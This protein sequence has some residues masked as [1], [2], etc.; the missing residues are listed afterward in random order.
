MALGANPR[1]RKG[2]MKRTLA[3]SDILTCD[4]PCSCVRQNADRE[5]PAFWRTQLQSI[6]EILAIIMTQVNV[7]K[8]MLFE[9]NRH[10]SGCLA[11][12]LICAVF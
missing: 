1:S 4:V 5:K 7:L 10:M 8:T 3:R 11:L 12:R 2:G 6:A 9:A